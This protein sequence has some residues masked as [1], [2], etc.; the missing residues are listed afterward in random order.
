MYPLV[1]LLRLKIGISNDICHFFRVFQISSRRHRLI[2]A[3]N[4]DLMVNIWWMFYLTMFTTIHS[5]THSNNCVHLNYILKWS[6]SRCFITF[7]LF[8]F[9]IGRRC[10]NWKKSRS[11]SCKWKIFEYFHYIRPADLWGCLLNSFREPELGYVFSY[12]YIFLTFNPGTN[13]QIHAQTIF[14]I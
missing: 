10:I 8:L 12:V 5:F 14:F 13:K 2:L 7:I 4:D 11:I 3:A 6:T 9:Y 1:A